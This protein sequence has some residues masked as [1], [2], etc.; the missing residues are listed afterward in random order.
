M[1]LNSQDIKRI[2][3][4]LEMAESQTYP[5]A[6]SEIHDSITSQMMNHLFTRHPLP[7]GS[8]VLDV[9]CGQGV[10]LEKFSSYGFHA[11]GI[12]L[13][14]ED[15]DICQGKEF[16]VYKMDQT[17]LDFEPESFD[18][19]WNRHCIEHSISPLL[20]LSSLYDVLMPGGLL[21]IEVPAPD[22]VAQHQKN[23]NHYSVLTKSM[24]SELIRR[25]GFNLLEQ[26]DLD[27]SVDVGEDKYLA[28]ISIKQEK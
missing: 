14:Q 22:T 2:E 16:E 9:G 6:P 3:K 8:R 15:V 4:V 13:N 20:T 17:F 11:I 18:L 1:K 5:E 23:P 21:Y 7:Q 12:T 26:M 28:F 10:A 19:V 27:L 25:S 24:W